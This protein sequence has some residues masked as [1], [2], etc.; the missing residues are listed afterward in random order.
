MKAAN[1]RQ[2]QSIDRISIDEYGILGTVLMENAGRAVAEHAAA[3]GAESYAVLCGK[4]NNGG[5]GSVAARH[6]FNMGKKVTLMLIGKPDELSNDAKNNFQTAQKIGISTVI[7]L[8]KKILKESD[9]II[10]ALLGI[11]AKGAP[12]GEIKKAIS[13]INDSKKTV[14]AVDVPS[15]INADSGAVEG[16]CVHADLT[17]TF[18]LLKIGLVC[19]P[20]AQYA[21]K[22]KVCDISFAPQAVL[23]QNIEVFTVD[24]AVIPKRERLSHKGTFGKVLAICGSAE[25]TG[26]A[27]LSATAA[28]K[29]GCG[30]VTLG[31]PQSISGIM[32]QKLTEVITMP[33]GDINGKL[34]AGCIPLIADA[35]K[36]CSS[37]ICGCGLGQSDD[38]TEAVMHII[39]ESK[40]PIVLD[41]DGINAI[42]GH[43]DILKKKNCDIIITPHI[44][45]MSRLTGRKTEYIMNN[46]M[47]V[48]KDFAREYNVITVLKGA[49]T[50][51]ALP[52]GK[53]YINTK[54][55]SGM[56]TAGSGDVLAGII[57]SFVAQGLPPWQAAVSGVYI[58]SS[59]GDMAAKKLGE[60]GM[61]A[62]DILD[63]IPYVI[64]EEVNRYAGKSVQDLV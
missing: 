4:G 8:N 48:A 21:G 42:A 49:N 18:G 26:A 6:L 62:G 43:K 36:E 39:S 11:G 35:I 59:A 38:I 51:I 37:I 14:I 31:V 23:R 56:A 64:R 20:A 33:L 32:A 60:H 27:Y 5:D 30:L 34:S 7:G 2:M 22:V 1:I 15:G 17:V 19:Y 47:P 41:A 25:Y 54:G 61:I 44:G 29:S 13:A 24:C 40:K 3:L 58:H 28:L 53:I 57:G 12:A 63:N 45:E 52:D 46:F 55:N 10:D 9:I 16:E 50:V